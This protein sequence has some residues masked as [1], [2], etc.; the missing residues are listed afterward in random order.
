M[1]GRA[2]L[3]SRLKPDNYINKNMHAAIAL[4]FFSEMMKLMK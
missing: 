2:V 4:Q 3:S 1:S